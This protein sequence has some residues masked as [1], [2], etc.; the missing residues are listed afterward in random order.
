MDDVY[1][2]GFWGCEK[3]YEDIIPL[4]QEKIVFPESSNPKM[5]M[6]CGLW[7]VKMP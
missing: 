6:R 2:Y 7:Q 1:L 3:Y 4:L 5:L